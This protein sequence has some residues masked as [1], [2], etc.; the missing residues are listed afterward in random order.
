MRAGPFAILVAGVLSVVI[1]VPLPAQTPASPEPA[2]R[3]EPGMVRIPA[4]EF[5]LGRVHRNLLDELNWRAR[6]RMDDQ[7][8][9]LVFIDSFDI[10]QYEATNEQYAA[11]TESTGRA[12]PYHWVEG[13]FPAGRE[14]LPVYNVNWY[15]ARAYCGWAWKRLPTESEWERAARG[16]LDRKKYPW[17]DDFQVAETAGDQA[18]GRGERTQL[19]HFGW[20]DGPVEV[21]SLPPNGFGMYDATGNVSEWVAD[22]YE[23]G[24]Y[25]VSPDEN[26]QGPAEG[27][28]RVFRGG[29]WGDSDSRMLTLNYRN[30]T[31]P[32]L[33]TVTLGFR[34]AK[35]VGS[36]P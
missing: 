14:R 17:G 12:A 11:F 1:A 16:G 33:R 7:P 27:V 23:R 3:A 13:S 10:D 31:K 6:P 30:Y 15:E 4:G 32:S 19:A 28:Y 26:P 20:P 2:E 35:A 21:G 5:W 9:H 18:S 25:A 8:A 24:Y 29:S 34:C 36:S 22:W